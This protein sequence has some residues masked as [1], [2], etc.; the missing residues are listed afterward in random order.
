MQWNCRGLLH[1]LDDVNFLLQKHEPVALCLQETN[2]KPSN[3]NFLKSFQLFRKDRLTSSCSSGGVAIVV[4]SDVAACEVTLATPLEAVA[5]RILLDRLVTVC[6]LYIPP[7][8]ALSAGDLE[9]LADQLPEPFFI[10][11]DF[12]AH[13]P[14]WGSQRFDSRGKVIERFVSS[15]ELCVLNTGE[16]TYFS[17][18]HRSFSCIDLSI[19]SPDIFTFFQWNVIDNPYGSDHFPVHLTPTQRLPRLPSRP[20]RWRLETANWELFQKT[21]VFSHDL[22]D[23]LSVDEVNDHIT[24]ILIEAAR[25]S[26]SQ[27]TGYLPK[28]PKPW[29]NDECR[30]AKKTQNK[31]WGILRRYPTALNVLSFK[32][33]RAFA[34]YVRKR[35]KKKSWIGYTSSINSSTRVK[36]VWDRV[37]KIDGDYRQYSIPLIS[38]PDG[39][40]PSSLEEQANI[41]GRHFQS[42]SGCGNYS[43]NFLS[44]KARA[45]KVRLVTA[46]SNNEEYNQL[47]TLAELRYAL[48]SSKPSA[49]GSDRV[50]YSMLTHLA[51]SSFDF[52]LKFF[53]RVWKEGQLPNE[54]KKA[55]IVPFLKPGKDRSNASS[56]RPI[57]LTSCLGKTFERLV[58][59]RL[60]FILESNSLLSRFQCGFRASRSTTDH[61]VRLETGIREA[62][63]NRQFYLSV[64]FDLEKAYDTTWRYGILQDLV[65]VGI[66]GRMFNCI[67]NFL[68]DRTFQVRLGTTLSASFVQENGVP[69][70]CVLSVTLFLLK[71]NSLSQVIPPNVMHSLYVDDVQIS[72]ASCNLSICERQL[73]MTINRM[74]KWADQNGFK[75]STEKTVV[76]CFSQRRGLFP[77]PSLHLAGA[78]LPVRAE[79]RFL[80]VT[81]DKKL[82]FGSHIKS[83]RLRCQKKLNIMRVLSHKSW[84]ADR[85]CLLRIYRAVVR[86]TLD[87]GCIVYG[88]AK[89]T[90][91]KMLD[92]IHHQGIRLATGAFRTSPVLSLYAEAN[93]WSLERRRL[94][95]SVQYSLRIR[96]SPNNP[97]HSI[98]Q[99]IQYERTF[100][101]R[102]SITKPFA[103]R[104][105][106]LTEQH[107]FEAPGPFVELQQPLAPWKNNNINCNLS[108]TKYNKKVVSADVIRQEF[109]EMHASYE[110]C[111]SLFTDGTKTSDYVGCAFVSESIQCVRRINRDAT[112][113]TA[114]LYGLI[115]AVEHILKHKF[116]KTVVFSD[117]L[118]ALRALKS[119]GRKKNPLVTDLHRRVLKALERKLAIEFCWVPSHMG[120][121][122]N[123][124]ADRAAAT[125]ADRS[126][127]IFAIPAADYRAKLR[128]QIIKNWQEEWDTDTHNKLHV[129]KSTLTEW[130]SCR[131]RERF[132][133][134]VLCRLRIGHTHLTHG[135]LLR[136]EEAPEC[137]SCSEPLTIL[138]IL[139]VCPKYECERHKHFALFYHEHVPFH[140]MLL[141][142]E[143]PLIPHTQVY[144]FLKDIRLIH[145]L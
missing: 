42:I 83:L 84:G 19:C 125:S 128:R 110:N 141:L 39:D 102:P 121:A 38:S 14:L 61:L 76:V 35:A 103:L 113:F 46:G 44:H 70:G 72:F 52:L 106:T 45:E 24:T 74:T 16:P 116:L 78:V 65:H 28:H 123:E 9:Q 67:A 101:N 51:E 26:I 11:G 58:N 54:W 111:H 73:Q 86:S 40:T 105:K 133:E 50:H 88:S 132:Y 8:F 29:W 30:E 139:L 104:I 130:K 93:E 48:A 120:I 69:Q 117:S 34:R 15:R 80:G 47:F 112:V 17:S 55:I 136:G 4:K 43:T 37:R 143:E 144:E 89:A 114:E 96:S 90:T 142:G 7:S 36:V 60:I 63:V 108:L 13:N 12:N 99:N 97:V 118:S 31:F 131:H 53:N 75:F 98:I 140:L 10:L 62:F 23:T 41:L 20:P 81:F 56:Y 59:N 68:K 145:R 25:V 71:I 2:L 66:R 126:V 18:S 138:H 57:A 3:T 5:A 95:L 79:H 134:V 85:V 124:E 107:N 119:V 94:F 82:T 27:T 77:D 64:F 109:L 129:I 100:Q 21:A 115:M 137:D 1:N 91:L 122:G 6:S 33:K 49:P 32:Q 92:P 135:H 22:L 127:D 87:Y